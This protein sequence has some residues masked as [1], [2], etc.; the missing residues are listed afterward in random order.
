RTLRLAVVTIRAPTAKLGVMV[1]PTVMVT[2][3]SAEVPPAPEHVIEYVVVTEGL[4]TT[5]PVV[6]EALKPTPV[7]LVALVEVQDRLADPPL[8]MELGEAER[9]AVGKGVVL[10]VV[11]KGFGSGPWSVDSACQPM[12]FQILEVAPTV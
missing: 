12:S 3:E 4:T 10:V 7:Q 5:E 6:P 9:V 8:V 2:E 11:T 1:V